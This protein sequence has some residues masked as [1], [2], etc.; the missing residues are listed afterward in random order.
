MTFKYDSTF[1]TQIDAYSLKICSRGKKNWK[2]SRVEV[3]VDCRSE[4]N[5]TLRKWKKIAIIFIVLLVVIYRFSA[6][7]QNKYTVR[8]FPFFFLFSFSFSQ[9]SKSVKIKK[10][11]QHNPKKVK[12]VVWWF[13]FKRD[14][15]NAYILANTYRVHS[16]RSPEIFNS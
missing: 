9:E 11:G 1:V 15:S 7:L 2:A 10:V 16:H 13:D 5:K 4:R 8:V 3:L 14:T 12:T 6:T